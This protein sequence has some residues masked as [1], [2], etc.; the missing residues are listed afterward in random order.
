MNRV[1][2]LIG[3]F[4]FALLLMSLAVRPVVAQSTGGTLRGTITDPQ[5]LPIGQVSV[6]LVNNQTQATITVMTEPSGIYNYPDLPVGTYSI[7]AEKE[8]F[9]KAVQNGIQ[10]FA[11]QITQVNIPLQVGAVSAT[12]EVTATTPLVQTGTS[13]ISNDFD[14]KQVTQLPNPELAGS[15]LSLA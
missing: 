3:G 14:T 10:V 9:Q 2:K 13:Q 15:P 12:V 5:G 1:S 8:G 6:H 4:V 11:N 7:T